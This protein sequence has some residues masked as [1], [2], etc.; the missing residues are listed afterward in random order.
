MIATLPEL[1]DRLSKVIIYNRD[2]IKVIEDNNH[3]KVMFY[4]DPPYTWDTRTETRYDTD[5]TPAEQTKLLNTIIKSKAKF[6]LSGYNNDEYNQILV[7]EN[8]WKKK[9]F[10]VNT[11]SGSRAPKSKQEVLWYN[12]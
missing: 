9:V 2:A 10:T 7:L 5:F 8:N 1:H 12:Y 3:E 11:V 6:L 4:L